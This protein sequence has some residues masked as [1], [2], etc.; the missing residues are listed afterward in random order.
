MLTIKLRYKSPDKEA[1]ELIVHSVIDKSVDINNTSDNFRFASAVAGFA[2]LLR[3]SEYKGTDNFKQVLSLATD[4]T[5]TDA[6]GYRSEFINLV[7][8]ASRH[9]SDVGIN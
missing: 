3:D 7:K 1:S 2:M 5:G 8:K 9:K 6:E 4:A